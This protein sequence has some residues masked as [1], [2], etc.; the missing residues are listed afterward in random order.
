[1][2]AGFRPNPETDWQA[3]EVPA[4]LRPYRPHPLVRAGTLFLVAI[5]ALALGIGSAYHAIDR[6][7]LFHSVRIGVWGTHP[8]AGTPQA[9]PYSAAMYART[10]RVPLASGEGI[11]F[12]AKTDSSGATL[13]AAC[14]YL[15]EGATPPARLW[16]LT[17]T[18]SHGR[19]V[20]TLAGRSNLI[21]AHLLRRPDG[22]FEI[23]ASVRPQPGNWLPTGNGDGLA[24]VLRLYDAPITTGSSLAGLTMPKISR[25]NCR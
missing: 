13:T 7:S 4:I 21:G 19:L 23:V 14:D 9:D 22:S 20:E 3:S 18:D 25:K 24:F 16:T 6:E 2:T 10:G 1:M 8:H 5:A 15:I 11:A 17:A 12:T